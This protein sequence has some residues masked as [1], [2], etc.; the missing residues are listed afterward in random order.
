ML[1][2]M[3]LMA[4]ANFPMACINWMFDRP[5][6]GV[7]RRRPHPRG[8]GRRQQHGAGS[9]GGWPPPGGARA[10][11][12]PSQRW[13]GP[14]QT[15]AT[16]SSWKAEGGLR[17]PSPERDV[18]GRSRRRGEPRGSASAL[19]GLPPNSVTNAAL[20]REDPAKQDVGQ[21]TWHH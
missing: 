7:W 20:S 12:A 6:E 15:V 19:D 3:P 21:G 18:R 13:T 10:A 4:G 16:T 14:S 2:R 17:G 8:C 5:K 11:A 9:R 1:A